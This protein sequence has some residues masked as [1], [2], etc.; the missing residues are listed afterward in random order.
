MQAVNH[1]VKSGLARSTICRRRH[2]NPC[3]VQ[4]EVEASTRSPACYFVGSGLGPVDYLTVSCDMHVCQSACMCASPHAC[5]PVRMHVC[6]Y[7]YVCVCVYVCVRV[8][9]CVWVCVCVCVCVCACVCACL[10]ALDVYG[11]LSGLQHT[12]HNV[13]QPLGATMGF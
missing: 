9:V 13:C 10:H 6:A 11:G 5:V 8:C 3:R 2:R 1:H 7:G 4:A 12:G